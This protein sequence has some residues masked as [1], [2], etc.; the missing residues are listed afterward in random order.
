LARVIGVVAICLGA[1]VIGFNPNR[2]D[3]V[4]LTLAPSHGIHLTDVVGIT[5]TTLGIVVLWRSPR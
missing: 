4:I 2:W 1:A 5:L 3:P